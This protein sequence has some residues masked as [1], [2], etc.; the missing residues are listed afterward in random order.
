MSRSDRDVKYGWPRLNSFVE[1]FKV[2]LCETNSTTQNN[3]I[4]I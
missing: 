3:N 1:A 2:A 4:Q